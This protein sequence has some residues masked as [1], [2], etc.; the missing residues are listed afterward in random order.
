MNEVK[1]RPLA[2]VTG[3]SSGIGFELARELATR[4]FDLLLTARGSA[5]EKSAMRLRALGAQVDTLRTDLA[6]FNGV[7]ALVHQIESAG[8]PVAF[9]ALN[10]GV[11]VG[12]DFSETNLHD[13]LNLIQ[14]NVV[15]TVHLAKH[16]STAMRE[17]GEGRM[18]FT[19]SISAT[20]PCPYEAVYG[21]SKA[22]V[23][24]FAESLGKELRDTGVTV[25]TLLP[26]PTDTNFFHRAGMD[27]T[28]VGTEMKQQN[29]PAVVARQGI[30]AAL[31]GESSV[32][33]GNLLTKLEA[34]ANKVIPEALKAERHR[35]IAEP[36]SAE[37]A[38]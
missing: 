10:A 37:H 24:S 31:K 6:T 36:G 21:A 19:S 23:Q 15:S 5:L 22:F 38:A 16:L 20:T 8:R 18:L 32:V 27:E 34:Y 13:E 2:V 33:G 11:G 1:Q 26:G 7:E 9:A 35:R 17:Q 3:A 14:L 4:G 28:K 30:E 25:T 12:G 29:S